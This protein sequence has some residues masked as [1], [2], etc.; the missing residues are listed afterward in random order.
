ML[1]LQIFHPNHL[2]AFAERRW[3]FFGMVILWLR[4]CAAVRLFRCG[5]LL[6]PRSEGSCPFPLL[7]SDQ[8]LWQEVIRLY[9]HD[10][11][12]T[13]SEEASRPTCLSHSRQHLWQEV[14]LL[15]LCCLKRK[16]D[17]EASS[18]EKSFPPIPLGMSI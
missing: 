18:V 8:H 2:P 13:H 15:Y 4:A 5:L 14:V 9:L 16:H 6:L 11:S 17:A 1:Q 3:D 12:S 10:S 7:R